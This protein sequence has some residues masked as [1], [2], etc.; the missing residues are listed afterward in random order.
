[1]KK[2]RNYEIEFKRPKYKRENVW[3]GEDMQIGL[4]MKNVEGI[5]YFYV[6]RIHSD[7]LID[8]LRILAG[9]QN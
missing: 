1:M 9:E 3:S 4:R 8:F 5:R 6:D 7:T 2:D